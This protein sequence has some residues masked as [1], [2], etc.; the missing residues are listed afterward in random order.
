MSTFFERNEKN[1]TLFSVIKLDR[2]NTFLGDGLMRM[3]KSSCRKTAFVIV[4]FVLLLAV[5]ITTLSGVNISVEN[6]GTAD[7]LKTV[8]NAVQAGGGAEAWDSSAGVF[9]LDVLLDLKSKIF[10]TDDPVTYIKTHGADDYTKYGAPISADQYYVIKAPTINANV[11]NPDNGLV[12]Q[13]GGLYWMAAS[14]T[15]ADID[16]IQDNVI[17]TLYASDCYGPAFK[18]YSSTS[19]QRGKNS[20]SSLEMRNFLLTDSGLSLFADSTSDG[21]AD[22]YLVQPK[23]IA[24]QRK[25]SLYVRDSSF[26]DLNNE[27]LE[28]LT[29]GHWNG[30]TQYGPSEPFNGVV[31]NAWGEDYI[32][33]PSLSEVGTEKYVNGTSVW[34]LT[35]TQKANNSSS[36]YTWFRSTYSSPYTGF[37]AIKSSGEYY[38]L[39]GTYPHPVRPA[40]HL[41]LTNALGSVLL[42]PEDVST[43]YNGANQTI[44]NFNLTDQPKWYYAGYYPDGSADVKRAVV[45]YNPMAPLDSS[46][47][48]PKNAGEYVVEVS[49]D[50]WVQ[51]V[52]TEVDNECATKGITDSAT[53]EKIKAL[54]RPQFSGTAVSETIGGTTFTETDTVRYFKLTISPKVVELIKT[55]NDNAAPT[56]AINNLDICAVDQSDIPTMLT[57]YYESTDGRNPPYGSANPPV[58]KKGTYKVTARLNDSNYQIKEFNNSDGTKYYNFTLLAKR[59]AVPVFSRTSREY[60]GGECRFEIDEKLKDESGV[61]V[62]SIPDASALPTEYKDYNKNAY[63]WNAGQL[64]ASATQAGKYVLKI[65]LADPDNNEWA[66]V[67]TG[68]ATSMSARYAVFEIT[69]LALELDFKQDRIENGKYI[70]DCMYEEDKTVSLD[71]DA[72]R[73]DDDKI[74]IKFIAKRGSMERVVFECFE[75]TKKLVEAALNSFDCTLAIAAEIGTEGDYELVL[76]FADGHEPNEN[77]KLTLKNP[78]T[79][80]VSESIA[81]SKVTWR[82]TNDGDPIDSFY[83]EQSETNYTYSKP[84]SYNGKEFKFIARGTGIGYDVDTNYTGMGFFNGYKTVNKAGDNAAAINVGEYTTSVRLVK[85]G[86]PSDTLVFSVSFKIDKALIDLSKIKW[87]NDGNIEWNDGNPQKPAIDPTTLPDGLTTAINSTSGVAVGQKGTASVTFSLGGAAAQ[88][89]VLPEK[90]KLNTYLLDGKTPT[91]EWDGWSVDWSV[92]PKQLDLYYTLIDILDKNNIPVLAQQFADRDNAKYI[93]YEYYECD[94][95][96]N[97]TNNTPITQL[98]VEEN[99]VKYY[100]AK[101][102]IAPQFGSNV[103][104]NIPDGMSEYSDV[105]EVGS[106]RQEVKLSAKNLKVKYNGKAQP[107]GITIDQGTLD[108]SAFNI[109]YKSGTTLLGS[110]PTD[111]GIYTV[112]ITLKPLYAANYYIQDGKIEFTYEIEK[113]VIDV[114]W[115]DSLKPPALSVD[116]V[117][118]KG[119]DYEYI[120]SSNKTVQF[121]DLRKG[122]TY[123]VRAKIKDTKNFKF[124]ANPGGNDGYTDWKQF[125]IANN[126]T[127]YNPTDPGSPNY[128]KDEI[129]IK[130]VWQGD[131]FVFNGQPQGPTYSITDM[132]GNPLTGVNVTI[133]GVKKATYAHPTGYTITATAP[134]GYRIAEG[135]SFTY[136]IVKNEETGKGGLDDPENPNNPS[137]DPGNDPSGGNGIDWSKFPKW[138]LPTSVASIALI[139]AFACIW[140]KFDKRRNQANKDTQKYN[141]AAPVT[142]LAVSPLVIGT[143]KLWLGMNTTAWSSVAFALMGVMVLMLVM[144]LIARSRC[145]KAEAACE[146]ALAEKEER[147]LTLAKRKEE[148]E[149][150]ERRRIEEER[151]RREAEKEAQRQQREDELKMMMMSMMNNNN[152]RPAVQGLTVE[153]TKAI[154]GEMMQNLLPVMTQF[155]PQGQSVAYIPYQESLHDASFASDE[156]DEMD[157]DEEWDTEDDEQD[158]VYEAELMDD[159]VEPEETHD[160]PKRMPSNFRARL[161]VSSDK[162]RTTYAII[163]NEFCAHKSVSYRA[164]GRVEKV[165]FHGDLIAVIGVAKRSIKLWLA[166][167]PNE[168]DRDRYFHKDVSDKPR[169]EKVPMYLRVGSERAQK[170][171]LELLEA[172]FE[173][174]GIE[175]RHR[176]EEK[177]IQE[178]IFTLKGNKL[179]K[180]KGK[181]HLLSESVHVHDTDKLD[182]ETAENCIEIKDIAPIGEEHFESISLD[183]IDE[184]FLDGQRVTLEKLKKKGLVSE[185]CN[186]IRIDAGSRLSKPLIIFANEFS[187]SA[188]KMVV[189]TGGRAVQLVQF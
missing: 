22:K 111:A 17:L 134:S 48:I 119:I 30:I 153:D 13:I 46:N 14:L 146:E 176:Y 93:A 143:D 76:A 104:L 69:A 132:D 131:L 53:I 107:I 180:D 189:L 44:G 137:Y 130:V 183:V 28:L 123:S 170:R 5:S 101:A 36:G 175:R 70:I 80:H 151:E 128:P 67:A 127:I 121:A 187:L 57:L 171:V 160:V 94:Q 114:N 96:G 135:A 92:V 105:F 118:I 54:R 177:P 4:L 47:T 25:Q 172:L 56:I 90:G 149:K 116:T 98:E 125:S 117:Q 34:N 27:A 181:K 18:Q 147:E 63:T 155:L 64:R 38:Y 162:N 133:G 60:N 58:A 68:S 103:V 110:A 185:N 24:Y 35:K 157:M 8:D 139:I 122:N 40:I 124:A 59:R 85:N 33:I 178:L 49:I 77:Y 142:A 61:F 150:A 165:K 167:D 152:S 161:K 100:V 84:I 2:E 74:Y 88:N 120:D 39:D 81:D 3:Q 9:N 126:D 148:E 11:G 129:P 19:S 109:S 99:M 168:F 158:E 37:Q 72:P 50:R 106:S 87:A 15:L 1:Y 108:E 141:K 83:V 71:C 41:N 7:A 102:M 31:S 29:P 78:I 140:A 163:K 97:I 164:C 166:L 154:V 20:Y 23:Y 52:E 188:V 73:T 66:D 89:Y 82:L 138:Q 21:F 45:T 169:Y 173:K 186:G 95:S 51:A 62:Y 75:V 112:T 86:N 91:A 159:S 12:I 144:M 145:L 65:E 156:E 179:L 79:L 16:G 42:N 26:Y 174:F 10:G 32:W 55:D 182:S 184:N 113:N 136:N 6:L 43:V 115:N